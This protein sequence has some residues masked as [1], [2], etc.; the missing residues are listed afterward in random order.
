MDVWSI[1]DGELDLILAPSTDA[2]PN[3]HFSKGAT[4]DTQLFSCR[5]PTFHTETTVDSSN[6]KYTVSVITEYY[7]GAAPYKSGIL[8]SFLDPDYY[9]SNQA[10]EEK[11]F[12]HGS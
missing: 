7:S 12:T 2:S 10:D 1:A 6:T 3:P 5:F 9:E 4:Q 8:R 11:A